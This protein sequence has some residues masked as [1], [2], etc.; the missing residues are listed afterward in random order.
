MLNKKFLTRLLDDNYRQQIMSSNCKFISSDKL[1]LKQYATYVVDKFTNDRDNAYVDVKEANYGYSPIEVL[2]YVSTDG[3][4]KT[5]FF[6]FNSV[7]HFLKKKDHTRAVEVVTCIL[8]ELVK[9]NKKDVNCFDIDKIEAYLKK[10]EKEYASM[11]EQLKKLKEEQ[12]KQNSIDT[13][14]I[15][16]HSVNQIEDGKTN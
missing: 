2:A 3:S 6:E 16:S 1:K 14:N 10:I 15:E 7:S 12:E 4:I 8:S 5:A 9:E 11:Q 13:P